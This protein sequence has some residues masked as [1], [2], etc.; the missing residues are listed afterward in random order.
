L[1]DE[2]SQSRNQGRPTGVSV[3]EVSGA[4]RLSLPLAEQVLKQAERAGKLCRDEGGHDGDVRF[5]RNFFAAG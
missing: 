3:L 5:W 1:I 2:V 4:L